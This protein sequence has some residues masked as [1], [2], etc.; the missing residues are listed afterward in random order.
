[1]PHCSFGYEYD[2]SGN[3]AQSLLGCGPVYRWS[4]GANAGILGGVGSYCPDTP[5]NR[6]YLHD[7]GLTGFSSGYC[8]TC[9]NVP[10]GQL[11][12]F[13]SYF[14][15]PTCPSSCTYGSGAGRF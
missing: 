12:V 13:W 14:V 2:D 15:G 3:P 4:N 1:L 5:S 10:C 11:F 7:N 6:Q 8:D 9:L